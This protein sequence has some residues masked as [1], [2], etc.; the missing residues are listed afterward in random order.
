[1]LNLLTRKHW[2]KFHLWLALVAGLFIALLGISGSLLL[3][4]KPILEW[5]IGTSALY[6]INQNTT[7]QHQRLLSADLWRESATLAYPQLTKIMGTAEPLSGFIPATNAMVFGAAGNNGKLGIAFIDPYDASA[8]GFVIFDDLIF[9]KI[10]SLHR[11]LLLPPALGSWLVFACGILL[12][13][14][15]ISGLYLWWPKKGIKQLFYS[16]IHWR[17]GLKRIAKWQQWHA[18]SAIYFSLPLLIIAATGAFLSQPEIFLFIND[19]FDNKPLFTLLH[20]E[21][22]MGVVGLVIAFASGLMLP[23]FYISGL[24]IWWKKRQCRNATTKTNRKVK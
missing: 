9:S 20:R 12:I 1:M 18:F 22:G 10:V 5:E 17:S 14:S 11:L 24:V 16:L 7:N 3:L 19:S 15:V 2:L 4:K 23:L 6:A 8:K 21:L 13:F